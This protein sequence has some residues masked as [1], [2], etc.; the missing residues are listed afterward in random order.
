MVALVG[1]G[2]ERIFAVDKDVV[3]LTQV[4]RQDIWEAGDP[5]NGLGEKGGLEREASEII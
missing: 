2:L 5:G 3:Y 4:P 1:I